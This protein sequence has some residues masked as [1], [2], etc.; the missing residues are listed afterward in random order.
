MPTPTR[1]VLQTWGIAIS[2][3]ILQNELKRRLPAVFL[4]QFPEGAEI[5]Y[6]IIP[7]IPTLEPELQNEVRAAFAE[8]MATIWKA[9]ASFS[10]AGLLSFFLVREVPM[11][12]HTDDKYGL[13][14][15]SQLKEDGITEL[16]TPS[17]WV[18]LGEE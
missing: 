2:A 9:M 13:N 3:S 1:H 11:Q 6:A 10:A 7:I 17:H 8:S 5:A 14:D 15:C 18:S 4:E 12:T 16:G